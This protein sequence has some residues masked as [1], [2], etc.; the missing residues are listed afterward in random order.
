MFVNNALLQCLQCIAI[1]GQNIVDVLGILSSAEN[2][3]IQGI[4]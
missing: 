4:F 2:T 1:V 3:A